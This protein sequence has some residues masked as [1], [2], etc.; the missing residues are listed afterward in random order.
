MLRT[1]VADSFLADSSAIAAFDSYRNIYAED[2]FPL[3]FSSI[4]MSTQN[5]KLTPIIRV[6]QKALNSGAIQHLIGLSSAGLDHYRRNFLFSL[7]TEEEKQFI[8]RH[9][10]QDI[11]VR[12]GARYESYPVSFFNIHEREWQGNSFD[13][14][15]RISA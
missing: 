3:T 10:E 15:A 1:G 14:L 2:F 12:I 8:R 11:A 9:T 6:V 5:P 4:A 7:F 13:I